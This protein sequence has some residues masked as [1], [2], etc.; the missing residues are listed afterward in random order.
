MPTRLSLVAWTSV[1]HCSTAFQTPLLDDCNLFKTRLLGS[2]SLRR[3]NV[4]T[5]HLCCISFTGYLL[6]NVSFI[7]LL[8]SPLK[9]C[10]TGNL[11]TW[12]TWS[13]HNA[14][15]ATCA[16][17]LRT[18]L[19]LFAQNLPLVDHLTF[20]IHILYRTPFYLLSLGLVGPCL[21]FDI[22]L[23]VKTHLYPYHPP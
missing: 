9:F 4:T 22:C 17:I 8:S 15:L 16:P 20:Q 1:T 2:F 5:F 12:L 21:L 3:R 7:K 10:T 23:K 14:L 13:L 11:H 18:C 6:N 19:F